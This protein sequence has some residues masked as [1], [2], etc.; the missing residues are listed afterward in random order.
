MGLT[1]LDGLVMGTRS[2]TLDPTVVSFINEQTGMSASDIVSMLNKKSG[3]LAISGISGDVRDICDA[4]E[5]GDHRAHIA[6]EMLF[7]SVRHYIG[8]YA[9]EMGR[10]DAIVFTAG[11]GENDAE[12]RE[13]VCDTL[14]FMGI[15]IDKEKND[16][17]GKEVEITAE[18]ATVRSFIIPTNE[19]LMIAMDTQALVQNM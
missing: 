11:I 18:G 15:K 2:G 6:R 5:K 8:A 7:K 19:E 17:R 12:L 13:K 4:E 16:V 14:G 3:L 10:V 1:P 9:A